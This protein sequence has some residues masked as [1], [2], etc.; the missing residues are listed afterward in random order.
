MRTAL[1]IPA[2]AILTLAMACGGGNDATNTPTSTASTTSSA[3]PQ[4]GSTTPPGTSAKTATPPVPTASVAA[5]APGQTPSPPPVAAV[6]TPA[7][8][9]AQQ[10][11]FVAS[12]RDK[13]T[14]PSDCTYN[15]GTAIATCGSTIYALNPPVSGQDAT[16]T[17]Y[18]ID[19]SPFAIACTTAEPVATTYYQLG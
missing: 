6:G 13:Q 3:A 10:A 2:L 9:P 14:E 17:L 15:P 11:A 19:G 8:A 5:T 12:F 7:V 1:L 18:K 4:G 16:C